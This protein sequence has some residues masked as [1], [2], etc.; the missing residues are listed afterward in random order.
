[1]P[2]PTLVTHVESTWTGS[3]TSKNASSTLTVNAGDFIVVV[4][5]DA[6]F[7]SG[8]TQSCSGSGVPITF[9]QA[10]SIGQAGY[11][12]I[13]GFSGVV[14]SAGTLTVSV[15]YSVSQT[16]GFSASQWRNAT[17]GRTGQAYTT[18][19]SPAEQFSFSTGTPGSGVIWF[20]DDFNAG[21][22]T[23]ATYNTGFSQWFAQQDTT[24]GYTTFGAVN[25]NIGTNGAYTIGST[26]KTSSAANQ[27]GIEVA[28]FL[29]PPCGFMSTY[30][31]LG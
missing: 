30:A 27:C 17:L 25:T 7:G 16:Y 26:N 10:F 23:S 6:G 3:A 8:Q 1:M 14:G 18:S 19:G 2:S 24:D 11:S 9:T 5:G 20:C 13:W 31:L 29:S 4:G 15:G 22:A 12:R 28:Y 21:T